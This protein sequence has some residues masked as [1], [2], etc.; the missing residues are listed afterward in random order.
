MATFGQIVYSVL[1]L[2]K[3]LG[4][5]SYYT[6]EHV[7]FL[8]SHMRSLLIERK[9]KQTRNSSFSEISDDNKQT[10]CLDLEPTE[11]LPD[12]CSGLW[13]HSIQEIPTLSS[14][15]AP[16][17]TTV[18]GLFFSNVTLIPAEKMPYVG[19]NKW[20]KHIVYAA[21]SNDNHLYLTGSNPQFMY[22]KKAKIEAVFSDPMAAAKLSCD[23]NGNS[24][25]CDILSMEFPL[26]TSLVPS[27]IEMVTQE[28]L[29]SRYAPQDKQNNAQDDL[30]D[31]AV[32]NNR[33]AR[34]GDRERVRQERAARED[35]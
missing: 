32:T 25:A 15:A 26:E 20:L 23:E 8:A 13:L 9:Y 17:L 31:I 2:M 29:G 35:E 7:I 14:V 22:L 30:A 3:E 18:S 16:K 19:Y 10:I 12:G 33:A 27:C 21:K 4:D 6:E 34:P 11:L 28:L 24:N 1:D 5:D